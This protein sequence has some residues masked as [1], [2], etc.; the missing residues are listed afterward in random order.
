MEILFLFIE[1]LHSTCKKAGYDEP[2]DVQIKNSAEAFCKK[3]QSLKGKKVSMTF[4]EYFQED[5]GATLKNFYFRSLTFKDNSKTYSFENN[6]T[7][8]LGLPTAAGTT[9]PLESTNAQ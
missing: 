4:Q 6:S 9:V 7:I 5:D 2:I 1:Y 8:I 3:L